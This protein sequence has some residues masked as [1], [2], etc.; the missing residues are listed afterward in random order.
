MKSVQIA[1]HAVGEGAPVFVVC[2]IGGNFNTLE[3]GKKEIDLAVQCGA[4]AV[5]IQTFRAETLVTRHSRFSTV[6]EGVNQY[7]LFKRFEVSSEWHAELFAH[8]AARGILA[9]STPS[10]YNDV[11][12]LEK[13]KVPVYKLG[14]DDL[15]NLPFLAYVASKKKPVILST[16]MADMQEA[17]EAVETVRAAGNPQVLVLHCVSGYPVLDFAALN[18]KAM[19]A[20]R[21][22]LEVPVGFSDHTVGTLASCA[23]VSLGACFIEKHFTLDKKLQTPDSFFSADPAEMTQLVRSIRDLE[24]ALGSG[25]KKPNESEIA[26]R[27]EIRKSVIARRKIAKGAAIRAED[28]IVK[29]PGTGIAPKDCAKVIGRKAAREI[30]EDELIDWSMLE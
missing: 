19:A 11:D 10:H 17:K 9:F 4:D 13:L 18:L 14:S 1:D 27:G 16:G 2:E 21:D 26:L 12:L 30:A 25:E 6:A 15:T 7:E 8:A 24:K 22:T 29:R 28:V 3:E 23:A 20:L 5:K